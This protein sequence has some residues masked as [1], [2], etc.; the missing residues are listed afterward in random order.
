MARFHGTEKV[1]PG[2]YFNL[3]ELRFESLQEKEALPGP[4]EGVWRRVPLLVLF[5]AAPLIGLA[6]L[7]F[8][9]LIGLL[10]AI[11]AVGPAVWRWLRETLA[12][13]HEAVANRRRAH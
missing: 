7:V 5:A 4:P 9:P 10:M 1:D 2:I 13:A 12:E 6:Y 8:L 11:G 3:S